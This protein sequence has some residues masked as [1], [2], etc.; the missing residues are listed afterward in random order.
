MTEEPPLRCT[1]VCHGKFHAFALA[2]QLARRGLLERVVSSDPR[3]HWQSGAPLSVTRSVPWAEAA[4]RLGRRA[5]F[6]VG[7]ADR[8]KRGLFGSAA[9]RMLGRP[10]LVVAWSGAAMPVL[11]RA[12]ARGAATVL[13]RGSC[14]SAHQARVLRE[15]RAR[16]GLP[17]VDVDARDVATEEAEYAL[18]DRI[19]VPST[20]AQRTFLARG[21]AE[22]RLWQVPY[23]VDVTGFAPG[24]KE[25]GVFRVATVGGVG[26][27]KGVLYLLEAMRRLAL[28]RA[29]LL[30]VG[31]VHAE[32]EPLLRPYEG[33][34][35]SVGPQPRR[36]V[37]RL[38]RTASVYVSASLQEGLSLALREAQAT[39]LPILATDASGAEDVL[40]DGEEG[41]VVP[42]GDAAALAVRL[43]RLYR[44]ESLCRAFA[45]RSLARARAWTW[46][47]YGERVVAL[48]RTRVAR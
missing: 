22:E 44:D 36:E 29:E 27:Q 3:V 2:G 5:G 18:A 34:Y 37:A 10:D 13:E 28:P 1:V 46:D 47:D 31:P 41:F 24:P 14:H 23:G 7:A 30:L 26:L 8:L 33:L 4:L 9:V 43:E 48:Y 42:A 21:V 40:V 20:F 45:E 19:A 38:L 25:D 12:R 35:R 6:D 16:R 17:G 11:V 15:E 39:G 32:L